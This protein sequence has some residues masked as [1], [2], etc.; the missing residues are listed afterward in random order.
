[1]GRYGS[2][3]WC[4]NW[5]S[6]SNV[7]AH[8]EQQ[9]MNVKETILM[10]S[11]G[12]SRPIPLSERSVQV[13]VIREIMP[14]NFLRKEERS[15]QTSDTS[16]SETFSIRL[17]ER[18]LKKQKIESS[19]QIQTITQDIQDTHGYSNEIPISDKTFIGTASPWKPNFGRF[20]PIQISQRR[21]KW[22]FF[23]AEHQSENSEYNYLKTYQTSYNHSIYQCFIIN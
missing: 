8:E 10:W 12:S 7:C 13:K 23:E 5:K 4:G 11:G 15:M 19:E 22:L 2:V 14:Q 1:M 20:I 9:K 18:Q 21:E 17:N 6:H 16:D 3:L